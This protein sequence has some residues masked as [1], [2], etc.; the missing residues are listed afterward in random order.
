MNIMIAIIHVP[1]IVVSSFENL[2]KQ[3]NELYKSN[4]NCT[5]GMTNTNH[6]VKITVLTQ[7]QLLKKFIIYNYSNDVYIICILILIA[8]T[9]E[10]IKKEQ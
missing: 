1:N 3:N 8:N 10:C 6:D 9:N 5:F 4:L 2:I 7:K